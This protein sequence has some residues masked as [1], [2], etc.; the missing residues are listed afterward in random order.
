AVKALTLSAYAHQDVPFEQVVEAIQPPRSLSHSPVFQVM[1]ALNN[2]PQSALTLPGL[3]LSE[4]ATPN[5][6]ARFDL[7]LLLGESGDAITGELE[8]ASDL[9]DQGTIERWLGY[10]KVILTEMAANADSKVRELAL[11]KEDERRQLLKDFNATEVEYPTH[12][13]LHELFEAQA[14]ES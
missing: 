1:L 12:K 6:T 8:Y 13:R 11:L 2:T 14:A 9:F 7:S 10:F 5:Q 4:E 3:K